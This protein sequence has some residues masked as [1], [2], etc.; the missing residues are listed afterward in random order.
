MKYT[1]AENTHATHNGSSGRVE[2]LLRLG[3]VTQDEIDNAEPFETPAEKVERQVA[4]LVAYLENYANGIAKEK[5]HPDYYAM[6]T[7]HD[8]TVPRIAAEAEQMKWLADEIVR[9]RDGIV[10]SG[11]LPSLDEL[12]ANHPKWDDY[13]G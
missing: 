5:G 12:V 9:Y 3:Y 8:S 10:A 7:L 4:E 13:P 11:E 1:N 2:D 6:R